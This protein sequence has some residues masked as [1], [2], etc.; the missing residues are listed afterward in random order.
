MYNFGN[1][2]EIREIPP[3]LIDPIF[4]DATERRYINH[5][6]AACTDLGQSAVHG[7]CTIARIAGST[8]ESSY[9]GLTL[10][11]SFSRQT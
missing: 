8:V 11:E 4:D 9:R 3:G 5:F 2:Y 1:R 6:P 10:N 7:I